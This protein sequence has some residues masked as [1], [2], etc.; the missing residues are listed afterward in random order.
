MNEKAEILIVDDIPDH[1]AF[2]GAL[3]RAAGYRVYAVT[4]GE[5]V[6]Q[7]LQ[8]K[9][10]ELIMLD[11]KMEGMD[12][13]EVCRRIKGSEAFS[14]IPIIFVTSET[15]PDIIRQGFEA[16]CCDYVTKP[17][18]KEEYLAR[19]KTHLDISRQAHELAAANN[20]LRLFCSAV[21]HD[22]KS[23]LNVI[24]ML[25]DTLKSELDGD[26]GEIIKIA[27][28]ISSKSS[29]LIVMIERLLEFSKMCNIAPHIK[30]LDIKEII[31]YTF[32]E[33][34]NMQPERS[35]V[36]KC[37]AL[38]TVMGDKVLIQMLV[39][40]LMTNAFK[41]T[42]HRDNAVIEVSAEEDENYTVITFRDNG[43]GFDM[44]YAQKLFKVFQ[45]LHTADEYE[46]SGVGLAIVDRIMKRHGGRV[47]AFGEVDNGAQ[48]KLFFQNKL[49]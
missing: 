5:M 32:D 33:L 34:K 47:E 15:Q 23:P 19:V 3:L 4:S 1:I 42:V 8:Q 25:I 24:N 48:F 14:D 29:Q 41:F 10:P 12:G 16:G 46:G 44:A 49:T 9:H 26:S 20:E 7:F 28:M 22:L 27:D 18:I 6:L 39:K 40:N 31:A 11:I 13:L 38:P 17:F 45:R 35:I 2:A 36:L 21:S 30:E 37:S 43:A